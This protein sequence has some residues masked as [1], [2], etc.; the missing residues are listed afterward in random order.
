VKKS[1]QEG[2]S[3]YCWL[4]EHM[5]TDT[6]GHNNILELIRISITRKGYISLTVAR[7]TL[8]PLH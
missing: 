3:K 2:N 7:D 6:D 1:I 8:S 5:N 4:E